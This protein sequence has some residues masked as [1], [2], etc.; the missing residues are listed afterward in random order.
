MWCRIRDSSGGGSRWI[1][2]RS[3]KG[4]FWRWW[5]CAALFSIM[6]W[7]IG[8]LFT[9]LKIVDNLFSLFDM[10]H[11]SRFCLQR[12][13]RTFRTNIR[14]FNDYKNVRSPLSS[15][16]CS[17]SPRFESFPWSCRLWEIVELSSDA[18]PN[19]WWDYRREDTHS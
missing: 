10:C 12:E 11:R 19:P 1:R 18:W 2:V 14:N 7:R 15:R 4:F 3:I 5:R 9:L 17:I 8:M 13:K 6:I 16:S